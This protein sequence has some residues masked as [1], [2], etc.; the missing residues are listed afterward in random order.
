[1]KTVTQQV[2]WTEPI[3]GREVPADMIWT[4]LDPVAVKLVFKYDNGVEIEWM[5][6][7]DLITTVTEGRALKAGE[8]DVRTSMALG[9]EAHTRW[10]V[11]HLNSPDGTIM[12]RTPLSHVTFFAADVAH[13]MP[14]EGVLDTMVD[15]ELAELL[16]AAE[17][18]EA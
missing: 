3:S 1:M 7:L 14:A 17:S 10:F 9:P 15:F 13:K 12:V 11:L 6:A 2:I 16:K 18:D 5:F 8:H 4:D